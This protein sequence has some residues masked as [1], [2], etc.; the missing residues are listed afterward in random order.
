MNEVP[1]AGLDS[2]DALAALVVRFTEAERQL[3]PLAL[4][5]PDIYQR[6]VRLV[7]LLGDFLS[8]RALNVNDLASIRVPAL[9]RLHG[10]ASSQGI[11]LTN[12]DDQLIVD[13]ALA[14]HYRVLLAQ[15]VDDEAEMITDRARAAGEK[16]APIQT[17]DNGTLGFAMSHQWVDLHLSSGTRLVRSVDV[18]QATGSP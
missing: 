12:L 11:V 15:G 6:S 14:Q 9:A 1:P 5:D 7:G 8:E 18:D 3:Y 17:P 2:G 16:W 13:A 4:V 10:V